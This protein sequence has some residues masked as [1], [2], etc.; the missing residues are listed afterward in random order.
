MG[1]S[2]R[3]KFPWLTIDAI[4]IAEKEKPKSRISHSIDSNDDIQKCLKCD[5]SKC[6]NC[7]KYTIANP[8]PGKYHRFTDKE[9]KYITR[10]IIE[11]YSYK[12]VK[13]LIYIGASKYYE[14]KKEIK[15]RL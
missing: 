14:I 10:L 8:A 2:L 1:T 5:K 4:A 7:L 13:A 9:K 3:G 11:G 6:V 15:E 12:E